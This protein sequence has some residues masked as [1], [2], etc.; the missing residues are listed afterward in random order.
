[1]TAVDTLP[2]V[3]LAGS[4]P[5]GW[6]RLS[7]GPAQITTFPARV[8]DVPDPVMFTILTE[9]CSGSTRR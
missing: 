7:S 8:R 4:Q 6:V 5:D 3:T 9:G 1:M 2:P